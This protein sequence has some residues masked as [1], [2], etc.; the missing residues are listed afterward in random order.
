MIEIYSEGKFLFS[1]TCLMGGGRS[2]NC[3]IFAHISY[4]GSKFGVGK[5]GLLMGDDIGLGLLSMAVCF[6]FC[7]T[8]VVQLSNRNPYFYR[9]RCH[10]P[11]ITQLTP[12]LIIL[13][14][15]L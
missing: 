15:R 8:N 11:L 12:S 2:A 13:C 9:L 6:D 7:S 4:Y 3:Q 14:Q 10:H 1:C 5:A